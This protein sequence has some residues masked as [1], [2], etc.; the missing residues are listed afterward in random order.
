[1]ARR[2]QPSV[3]VVDLFLGDESGAQLCRDLRRAS[4]ETRVLLISGA[5]QITGAA[6]RAAGA[7]GF[8]SK[9]SPAADVARAVRR[10]A[11]GMTMFEP[12]SEE[13]SAAL[14]DREREVLN[15][16]A[17]GATNREIASRLFLSPYTIKEHTSAV[18]RKLDVRNRAEA[19]QRGQRLGLL[20]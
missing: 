20:T 11:L 8:V 3:A 9:D 16:I 18:Y 12:E 17:T 7:S 1:M 6:A 19:V 5:G 14:S 13:S 15:L 2:H 4:P 10:V